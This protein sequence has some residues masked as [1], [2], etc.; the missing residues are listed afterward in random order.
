MYVITPEEEMKQRQGNFGLI[1][2]GRMFSCY[3]GNRER[4]YIAI[5]F[6]GD[7]TWRVVELDF[8][9]R[10]RIARNGNNILDGWMNRH[11]ES[12]D[13]ALYVSELNFDQMNT[14]SVMNLKMTDAANARIR[15]LPKSSYEEYLKELNG[16]IKSAYQAIVDDPGSWEDI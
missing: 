12:V 15:A 1:Q 7:R 14:L 9:N 6:K 11:E 8:H 4:T 3:N 16:E 10:N 5:S 13:E 2:P